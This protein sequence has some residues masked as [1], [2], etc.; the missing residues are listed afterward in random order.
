[1]PTGHIDVEVY[2]DSKGNR[3]CAVNFT[4]G[5]VCKYYRTQRFGT[6]ETCLFAPSQGQFLEHLQRQDGDGRLIPGDWCP[7]IT[8]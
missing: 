1:M 8:V 6:Y 3:T 2:F 4:T 7:I 5:Q